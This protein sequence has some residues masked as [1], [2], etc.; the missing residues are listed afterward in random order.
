[1]VLLLL[2]LLLP[3][4]FVAAAAAVAVALPFVTVADAVVKL[5]RGGVSRLYSVAH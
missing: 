2:L 4:R 3:N 1:L 5:R